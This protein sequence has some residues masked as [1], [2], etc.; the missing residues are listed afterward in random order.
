MGEAGRGDAT[1]EIR[2]MTPCV[3]GC[4]SRVAG[5]VGDV[6]PM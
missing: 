3:L 1:G 5:G 6:G 2:E 4:G